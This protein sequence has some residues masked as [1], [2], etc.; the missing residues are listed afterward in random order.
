[1]ILFKINHEKSLNGIVHENVGF[2]V[3]LFKGNQILIKVVLYYLVE[4]GSLV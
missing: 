4:L 2:C 3:I 1:M